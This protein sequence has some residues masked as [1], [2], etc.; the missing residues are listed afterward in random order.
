MIIS[1]LYIDLLYIVIFKGY[2]LFTVLY[3]LILSIL[4]AIYAK[5]KGKSFI[6]YTLLSI[7]LSPLIGLI[8]AL[9]VK[10]D[11]EFIMEKEGLMK[12]SYCKGLI[13]KDATICKFCNNDPTIQPVKNKFATKSF[14]NNTHTIE[15][16]NATEKDFKK[17][18]VDLENQYL[19]YGYNST[20]NK[21]DMY[22]LKNISN[23]ETYIHISMKNGKIKVEAYNVPVE[24]NIFMKKE[25]EEAKNKISDTS[26]NISIADELQKLKAL[27][28]EELLTNEEFEVQKA[29]LLNKK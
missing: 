29:K 25:K 5:S 28:D 18:K 11:E 21:D 12:C 8:I 2:I 15:L 27:L 26:L 13:K 17:T 3:W 20:I 9:I 4:V 24:P 22:S 1:I 10:P 14:S 16:T 7:M 23:D 6:G 19:S